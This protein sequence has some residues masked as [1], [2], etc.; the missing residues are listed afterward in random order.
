MEEK[1]ILLKPYVTNEGTIPEGSD[2]IIFRGQV[3]VNGGVIPRVYNKEFIALTEDSTM[4]KKVKIIKNE[5]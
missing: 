2:I 5:F 4:T 1:F 3:Y